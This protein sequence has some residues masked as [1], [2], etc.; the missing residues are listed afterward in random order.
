MSRISRNTLIFYTSIGLFTSV[1]FAISLVAVMINRDSHLSWLS[2]FRG[3]DVHQ[4]VINYCPSQSLPRALQDRLQRLLHAPVLSASEA[5]RKNELSCPVET[6][7][8]HYGPDGFWK[9]FWTWGGVGK[10]E[11]LRRRLDIVRYLEAV[12]VND[13]VNPKMYRG[14]GIVMTGGNS[15]SSPPTTGHLTVPLN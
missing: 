11:I 5:G 2:S 4:D 9:V 7:N 8:H 13:L 15:V 14:R 6:V 3:G 1:V 10:K 12:A